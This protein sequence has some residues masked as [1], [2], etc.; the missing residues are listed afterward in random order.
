M[1]KE[2]Y[3]FLYS[4]YIFIVV[5]HEYVLP[6]TVDTVSCFLNNNRFA[7]SKFN[8]ASDSE[9]DEGKKSSG[10]AIKKI[11]EHFIAFICVRTLARTFFGDPQHHGR[12]RYL[13]F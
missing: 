4:Q 1:K 12:R 2:V 9:R 11:E 8:D 5:S 7:H 10:I 3:F 13:F 6:D